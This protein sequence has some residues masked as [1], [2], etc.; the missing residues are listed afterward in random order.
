MPSRTW[1]ALLLIGLAIPVR[2]IARH[3]LLIGIN[4]Y[5]ASS[6]VNAAANDSEPDRD[7]PNLD[8]AVNDV[9]LMREMLIA[10]YGFKPA[11]IAALTD[12]QATR[13]AIFRKLEEHL[14]APAQKG[15][16][17]VFF[18]SGHGS[19]V[20][21]SLSPELD[22]LDESIL[23]ADSRTGAAD[24]RDKEL[25]GIFNR[26][27]DRGARLTIILDTCHSGSGARGLDGGLRTRGV[28]P[29]LHD[30]ADPFTAPAPE[31]RGALVL[32]ATRD[33]DLAF[34]VLD[35]R[36]NI[37]GAFTWA[38][39][40]AMRD[41]LAGEPAI[42]TFQR[43]AAM[44]HA[45]RPAQEPVFAGNEQAHKTP[46][47]GIRADQR[48]RRPLIAI[49]RANGPNTYMLDGGW[50]SGV[51]IGSELRLPHRDD[52]RLEVTSLFGV[53]HSVARMT[54]GDAR[55]RPGT[56]LDVVTWAAPP[57]PP[58]RIWIARADE[59]VM[60][61]A[62]HL[63][64]EAMRRGIRW[65]DDPTETTPTYLLRRRRTAW[66]L[67]ANG[68]RKI[69]DAP[70]IASVP[71]GASLFVQLP[72]PRD[73]LETIDGINGVTLIDLPESAD[74]VVVGRLAGAE[75]E[76]ACVRPFVTRS[77][78][79]HSMLPLRTDWIGA[80]RAFALRDAIVRL[81]VVQGWQDL[82][83]PASFAS[84]Y[85]LAV[86][87]ATDGALVDD[88]K[89]IG[90]RRYHLVLRRSE[91]SRSEALYAHYVYAFVIASDGSSVLLFPPAER[92]D[93]ENLLP[94][95][96]TPGEP[97][98][99]A[100]IEIPLGPARPFV[101][102]EPYGLDTYFLLTTDEALPS[103]ASLEW[104]GVH[105]TRSGLPR[106]ALEDLLAQTLAGTRAAEPIRT[107]ANWSIEKIVFESVPPGSAAQ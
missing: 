23:P 4:D 52:V 46:L 8:G 43:A 14:V 78:V 56:L 45:E 93:V 68:R 65:L 21:N 91:G 103:L 35:D 31:E 75:V 34:E 22:R 87:R 36:G 38:L 94:I 99:D 105:R 1:I 76:Y 84:P 72:A 39:V 2:A 62:H 106:S 69:L 53:A 26:I 50:A 98:S 12:Q 42:E 47:F 7:V 107:P 19:Q 9:Q 3:A 70:S 80:A 11:D 100:P 16:I 58:L 88:G 28:R 74:Y 51:T 32:S 37:R 15:D 85:R 49:A 81:R 77:D 104:N 102:G 25:L 96:A 27:L 44:L 83:S 24:I 95:T 63:R 90:K 86:R 89:L 5:S 101:V 82:R 79:A 61:L 6:R 59:D 92:G 30:V 13:G 55:L 17:V 60:A 54:H 20:R 48:D 57:S 40:R 29:D 33:F 18:F 67:V 64:E 73:V 66:E 71:T 97:V 41:G 10:L